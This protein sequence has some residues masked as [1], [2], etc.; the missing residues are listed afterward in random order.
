[1]RACGSEVQ[2]WGG[3]PDHG[4]LASLP[5]LSRRVSGSF[6]SCSLPFYPP[7]RRSEMDVDRI[8]S[9]DIEQLAQLAASFLNS[10]NTRKSILV[11]SNSFDKGKPNPRNNFSRKFQIFSRSCLLSY[12]CGFTKSFSVTE[13]FIRTLEAR[14]E[15]TGSGLVR[16][17]VLSIAGMKNGDVMP[18]VS[19]TGRSKVDIGVLNRK[20]TGLMLRYCALV[21]ESL[22]VLSSLDRKDL[23]NSPIVKRKE[24][25]YCT[26][27]PRLS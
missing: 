21:A 27:L 9:V 2:I 15:T 23:A 20:K 12:V 25:L 7:L 22:S 4:P 16:Q 18:G 6:K 1:M 19:K 14:N 8:S 5:P 10:F 13:K 3:F 26:L 24:V 17:C 11:L